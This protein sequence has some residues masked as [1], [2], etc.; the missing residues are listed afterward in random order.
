M[1]QLTW[2]KQKKNQPIR[3]I[4]V[5]QIRH[6]GTQSKILQHTNIWYIWTV[7]HMNVQNLIENKRIVLLCE[8]P[9]STRTQQRSRQSNNP[10][11]NNTF[12]NPQRLVAHNCSQI[13][14]STYRVSTI[15]IDFI[16]I[17]ILILT[18]HQVC[19]RPTLNLSHDCITLCTHKF[20]YSSQ[21]FH[22]VLARLEQ[23]NETPF[24]LNPF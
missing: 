24:L 20:L 18:R 10:S 5:T 1:W 9:I 22:T 15:C 14:Q 6:R 17:L 16:L 19:C 3:N 13:W 8:S 21:I 12:P 11:Q 23:I 2:N 4:F 7:V